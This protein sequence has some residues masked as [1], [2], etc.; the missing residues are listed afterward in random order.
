MDE[1]EVLESGEKV[2]SWKRRVN[3]H[4]GC[5]FDVYKWRTFDFVSITW[6]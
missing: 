4:T 3:Y 5:T 2:G 1:E 6:P